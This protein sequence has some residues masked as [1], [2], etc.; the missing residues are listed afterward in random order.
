MIESEASYSTATDNQLSKAKSHN[1]K[2]E[3]QP[4]QTKPSPARQPENSQ[5][6]SNSEKSPI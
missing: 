6:T 1:P 2:A 3:K 4:L 5:S